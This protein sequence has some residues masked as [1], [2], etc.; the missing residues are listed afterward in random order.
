MNAKV[1]FAIL[2]LSSIALLGCGAK[3]EEKKAGES[4]AAEQAEKSVSVVPTSNSTESSP[5]MA[6]SHTLPVG[7]EPEQVVQL[8]FDYL[9][10]DDQVKAEACLSAEARGTFFRSGIQPTQPAPPGAAFRVGSV[11]FATQRKEL[12]YVETVWKTESTGEYTTEVCLRKADANEWRIVGMMMATED[13]KHVYFDF[14]DFSGMSALNE[15]LS[16]SARV[17]QAQGESEG[18]IR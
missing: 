15:G 13:S 16:E 8:Y 17:R 2:M 14:E 12:A 10:V 3:E 5:A 9:G 7:L 1:K 18:E 11:R 6:Q 4:K